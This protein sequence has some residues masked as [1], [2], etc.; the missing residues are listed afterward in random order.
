MPTPIQLLPPI[1]RGTYPT[2]TTGV[3]LTTNA[4]IPTVAMEMIPTRVKF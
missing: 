1:S 4:R 3:W 2:V